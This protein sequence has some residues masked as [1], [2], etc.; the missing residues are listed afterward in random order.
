MYIGSGG[1]YARNNAYDVL[2]YYDG[3]VTN[4]LLSVEVIELKL[5]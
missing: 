1:N 3:A 4:T 5:E 2:Q